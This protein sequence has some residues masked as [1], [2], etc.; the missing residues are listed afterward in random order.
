MALNENPTGR[1]YWPIALALLVGV[2]V[3]VTAGVMLSSRF[4]TPVGVQPAPSISVAIPKSAGI[5]ASTAATA[6]QLSS[7]Q[8]AL[9]AATPRQQIEATYL[10]YWQIY[11]DAVLNLDA[12]HLSDVLAGKALQLVTDEVG[13]LK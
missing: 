2:A 9:G 1:P 12:S 13:G 5:P 3:L 4:R 6:Q 8:S 11:S 7:A 10:R